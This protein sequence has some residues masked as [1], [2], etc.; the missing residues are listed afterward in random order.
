MKVG[1]ALPV[2]EDRSPNVFWLSFTTMQKPEGDWVLITPKWPQGGFLADIAYAR[3][4]LLNQAYELGVTHLIMMDTDQVYPEDTIPKLLSHGKPVV[5]GAVH[6]RYPPFDLI[7]LRGEIGKYKHVEDDEMYS[8]E[9]V[10]VDATGTGCIL[11][12]LEALK[13]IERP[14][15]ELINYNK[16]NAVGEDINL[17]SKIRKAGIPI[18]VDTSI[19]IDHLTTYRVN[20]ST[21]ELFKKINN[22]KWRPQDGSLSRTL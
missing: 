3:E 6:R 15:F 4:C 17:C 10:E 9:L 22:L 5:A 16:P 14:W 19:Q 8:G 7:M 11:Y 21:Y 12:D 2:I 13:D 18:Y 20:R 1:I